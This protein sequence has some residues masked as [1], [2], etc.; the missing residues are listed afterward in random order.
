MNDRV[1]GL[2]VV[3]MNVEP[4]GAE[5]FAEWY[6]REHIPERVGVP[7]FRNGN[8]YRALE[9]SP[10]R[11]SPDRSSPN[12]LAVY[13]TDAPGVL[14]SAAYKERLNTPTEWTRR[15][16]PMFRD[17]VRSACRVVAEQGTGLGGVLRTVRVEPGAGGRG[18]LRDALAALP[19]PLLAKP[20]IVRV[21]LV[22]RVENESGAGSGVGAAE[23]TETTE[24]AETAMRGKDQTATFTL[25]VDGTDAPSLQA[26]C[27][28][29]ASPERLTALG[30]AG[31]IHVGDYALMYN[32]AG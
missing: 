17:T 19:E 15:V 5:D 10:D 21:R 26:A 9:G 11:G 24:T 16:M 13:D 20:G 27:A 14:S 28:D 1:P 22:E 3:W 23:S 8:R 12:Y 4:S 18:A 29:L 30:A 7:G 25:L 2:L 6:I 32:L 31:E